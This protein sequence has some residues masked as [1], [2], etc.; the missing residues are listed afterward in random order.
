MTLEADTLEEK[1]FQMQVFYERLIIA[2]FRLIAR[3]SRGTVLE[4][5]CNRLTIDDGIHH[6][7]GMAYEKVLLRTRRQEDEAARSSRRPTGSCRSS[8]STQC[9]GRKS[10]RSSARRCAGA[11]SSGCER[12]SSSACGSPSRSGSTS[13]TSSSTFLV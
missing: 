5:L 4:D 1:V 8:S 2:R 9:G 3:A 6:G 11:T 12:T 10:A 13:A 7:A